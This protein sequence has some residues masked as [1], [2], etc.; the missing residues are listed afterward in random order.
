[1][2][3]TVTF[4]WGKELI[5][6]S[7]TLALDPLDSQQPAMEDRGLLACQRRAGVFRTLEEHVRADPRMLDDEAT[8]ELT[9]NCTKAPGRSFFFPCLIFAKQVPNCP[10]TVS[11]S[12]A[13]WSLGTLVERL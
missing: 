9:S 5:K 12:R 7:L 4:V 1:M 6:K 8:R 3:D 11:R 13:S 2:S 10:K